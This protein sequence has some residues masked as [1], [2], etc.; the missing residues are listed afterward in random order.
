MECPDDIFLTGTFAAGT[1]VPA[2][3]T[4]E[5]AAEAKD[6]V[7]LRENPR[8]GE[9]GTGMS[10]EVPVGGSWGNK[11]NKAQGRRPLVWFGRDLVGDPLLL[12]LWEVC[13]HNLM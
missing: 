11:N 6:M 1:D 3:R 13:A 12:S 10:E 4:S 2:R 9:M 8:G 7:R 5:R